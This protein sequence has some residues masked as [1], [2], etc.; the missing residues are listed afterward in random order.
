MTIDVTTIPMFPF[1]YTV[2]DVTVTL[3]GDGTWRGDGRAFLDAVSE[4]KNTGYAMDS[5]ITWLVAA[6]IQ[7]TLT[8]PA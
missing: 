6:A 7:R 8:S 3:D 1:K 4:A 2:N 5:V